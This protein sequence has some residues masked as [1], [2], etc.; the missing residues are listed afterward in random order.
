M[1]MPPTVRHAT[2]INAPQAVLDVFVA[3]H[4]TWSSN[5][6]VN[7]ACARAHGTLAT[8]IPCTGHDTRGSAQTRTTWTV[9]ASKHRH[10][11]AGAPGS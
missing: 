3:S 11:R 1:M 4:A 2:R 7:R 9:P 6:R 8:W 5:R 10:R